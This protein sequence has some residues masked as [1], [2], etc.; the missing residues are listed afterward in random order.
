MAGRTYEK[1]DIVEVAR[2]CGI[3]FHPHQRNPVEYRAN[4]PFCGDRKYHL[5]LNRE[6]EQFH[7]FRCKARGNS[8]SLYAMLHNIS[9]WQ[10]YLALKENTDELVLQPME[11]EAA[12]ETPIRSLADRH[13]VY[14][15]FL[16]MLYL[17]SHHMANLTQRGLSFANIRQFMYKSIPLDPVFCAEVLEKLSDKHDLLGIPGFYR[18]SAGR[19]QMYLKRCGGIFIPV[20]DKDGYIQ[21]LQMRLDVPDGEKRFRWFSSNHYPDGT[22]ARSWI[23][24]VG[25]V[26]AEYACLTEGAMKSDIASVLSDGLL[27]IAVPGVHAVELLPDVLRELRVTKIYEAFDMDKRSKIE[28]KQAL[29]TVRRT[30][31]EMGIEY[32]GCSWNPR[33]KGIDDYYL[34]KMQYA[35]HM[36]AAA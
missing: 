14:C 10:A 2:T 19:W 12:T 26:N 13:D 30:I 35:A 5:G 6:K 1:F 17:E 22:K 29:I 36:Q 9:N 8:V 23:H 24:V 15:D 32:Q 25:D 21:G 33:Y 28:V 20:C 18:D 31:A 11:F 16:S 4:C 3:D 27:L 7:C 34:A